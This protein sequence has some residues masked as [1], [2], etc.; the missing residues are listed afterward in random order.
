MLQCHRLPYHIPS[1]AISGAAGQSPALAATRV[2]QLWL[3]IYGLKRR[4]PAWTGGRAAGSRRQ[5]RPG[6]HSPPHSLSSGSAGDYSGAPSHTKINKQFLRSQG[7]FATLNKSLQS[8]LW[9]HFTLTSSLTVPSFQDQLEARAKRIKKQNKQRQRKKPK[10]QGQTKQP[11]SSPPLTTLLRRPWKYRDWQITH[12]DIL[13]TRT[14]WSLWFW[15]QISKTA[16]LF[17]RA[18]VFGKTQPSL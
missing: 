11:S 4:S 7:N 16:A 17:R 1:L 6:K 5:Q 8:Q 14:Y 2:T 18:W 9:L 10:K 3:L 12:Q 13:F 15:A